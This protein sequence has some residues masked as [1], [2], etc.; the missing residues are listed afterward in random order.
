VAPFLNKIMNSA[1]SES[2]SPHENS[3]PDNSVFRILD[4]A[5]NRAGE[6]LR[7]VEDYLRMVIADAHLASQLKSLRHDLTTATAG[8]ETANRIAA[9]DSESDVGR[10]IQTAA[11]YDRATTTGSN[12]SPIIQSNLARVQ[13]SF[14][15]IEEF[16]KTISVD[17][18]Q[19]IEQLRYRT[20]TLEKAILTT[21]LSLRNLAES[22]LYVLIDATEYPLTVKPDT[23][24]GLALGD[25]VIQLMEAGVSLIQLRDKRLS[26]RDLVS[27]GRAIATLVRGSKTRFVMNDRADLAL[28]C[29]A[30]G[31]H[32]GQDD[33]KVADARRVLGATRLIGV[34][35]HSIE[36]ARAAVLDGANYIGVGPVF[37]SSTKSFSAHVGLELVSQVAA[38]IQLPAFAIGGIDSS[39]VDR[40]VTAGL[41][42]V[43]VSAAIGNSDN[44]R[45]S[46]RE[47]IRRLGRYPV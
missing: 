36:Q 23:S 40:I 37:T 32:L 30:D 8:I 27:A 42:R 31:V 28:A 10:N 34:S 38:E 29:G 43:A 2:T 3:E 1:S 47:L 11:E 33:L 24:S 16:S 45:E 21:V 4:A 20:Y 44:P 14:R 39:T 9:R 15:S 19:Q 13:Q 5:I 22:K 41:S 12:S 25:L 18:A 26:D 17:M 35:T 7:V 46:A 6:G